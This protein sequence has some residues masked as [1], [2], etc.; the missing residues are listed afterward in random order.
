MST[1]LAGIV[2]HN[3]IYHHLWTGLETRILELPSGESFTVCTGVPP[4]QLHPDDENVGTEWVVPTKTSGKC[5]IR[6]LV[7]I[8]KG[9]EKVSANIKRVVMAS[10]TDDGTIV[11]YFVNS[12]ITKPR[13]N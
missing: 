12:G 7:D 13:K 3:L 11:Y 2:S 1:E 6:Q 4:E 8:F 9:I 5:S 10:V